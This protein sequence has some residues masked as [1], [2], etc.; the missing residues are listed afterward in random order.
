MNDG[1]VEH[2]ISSVQGEGYVTRC[3]LS[4]LSRS[5]PATASVGVR[6]PL[7][8]EYFEE[9]A[10]AAAKREEREEEDEG[11]RR[12]PNT[13][14]Q[15]IDPMAAHDDEEFVQRF[16]LSKRTV[17]YVVDLIE[18]SPIWPQPSR[19]VRLM[20][21]DISACNYNTHRR[22]HNTPPGTQQMHRL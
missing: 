2:G 18:P 19:A 12:R 8:M 17:T 1:A 4:S 11:I 13:V 9:L 10:T 7:E 15:R 14:R 3:Q 22:R 5:L 20:Y 21:Y 6:Q 16:R